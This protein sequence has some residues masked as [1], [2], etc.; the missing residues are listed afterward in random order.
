MIRTTVLLL[1]LCA[2][3]FA[4]LATKKALTLE[5][6]KKLA[7]AAEAEARKNNWNVVITIL[8]EGGNPIYLER[9]DGTQV[10]SVDVALA[11]AKS[12]IFFKRPT[13]VFE[14]NLAAGRNGALKLPNA[15][16]VEGGLPLVLADGQFIGAVGVS[17]VTSAQD[18]I[19]AKAAVDALPTLKP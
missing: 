15:L 12:A 17:G 3:G 9:M 7:A 1:T 19:I 6:A 5:A 2:L 10:G 11:K 18:G 16:P 14:D 8:D 13:K 4:Q